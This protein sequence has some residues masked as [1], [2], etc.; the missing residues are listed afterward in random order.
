MRWEAR[1]WANDAREQND[2]DRPAPFAAWVVRTLQEE[3]T[4]RAER[5]GYE[6]QLATRCIP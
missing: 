2:I 6:A 3:H 5:S 1:A 4:L